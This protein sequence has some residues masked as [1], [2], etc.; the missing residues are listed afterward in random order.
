[1][2]QE[3]SLFFD[4][5]SAL[6]L[7]NAWSAYRRCTGNAAAG[8]EDA[9]APLPA[10]VPPLPLQADIEG[11]HAMPSDPANDSGA[12]AAPTPPLD[13]QSA[14]D[15]FGSPECIGRCPGQAESEPSP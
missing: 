2:Q 14:G 7:R 1:M 6:L 13:E 5:L 12:A 10:P 4:K 9:G 8:P 11:Q 15:G 3:R